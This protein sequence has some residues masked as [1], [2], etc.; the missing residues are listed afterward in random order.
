LI[1]HDLVPSDK[2]ITQKVPRK[3]IEYALELRQQRKNVDKIFSRV[4]QTEEAS[5][6]KFV[7]APAP[8]ERE[9]LADSPRFYLTR[10]T[11][12]SCGQP[13]PARRGINASR[14]YRPAS[15]ELT[16]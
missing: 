15:N 10:Q 3:Q 8:R 6:V 2:Q 4:F 13:R 7:L 16:K 12:G 11:R 14:A 1:F 5:S 9:P